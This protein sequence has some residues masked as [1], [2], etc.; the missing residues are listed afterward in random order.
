MVKTLDKRFLHVTRCQLIEETSFSPSRFYSWLKGVEE[1]K[2]RQP[3]LIPEEAV[4]GAVGVILDYPHFSGLK[5]QAYMIYHQLGVV[6]HHFYRSLKRIVGKIVF[7]EVFRRNLLPARTS[8]RHE[9]PENPGEIWAEDFTTVKVEGRTFYIGI[10]IDV[11]SNYYLGAAA[12]IRANAEF[13][14]APV[15]QALETN[16]DGPKRFML[17]DN[18]SQY[19]GDKHGQLLDKLDIVHKRIPACK[20]EYNGS[21]ECGVKEFKNVFYN[22]WANLKTTGISGDGA[23]LYRVKVAVADTVRRMNTE[24]P[25]PC[26]KG[27]TPNDVQ[28]SIDAEKIKRNQKYLE[29]ERAKKEIKPWTKNKW[30]LI[31]E[32]VSEKTLSDLELM[33]KFCFFLKRPL[34]K[35]ANLSLESV[36]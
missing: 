14:E 20:P 2:K 15:I 29:E 35:L 19:I 30:Q 34:R 11:F 36:G 22:I 6:S 17:S 31:Q 8:Y 24:I 9:R 26:L 3:K 32:V 16:G 4:R 23:L 5:G 21:C 33:T 28:K 10:L 13:V 12:S 25:R 27:V 1:R 18:G 7:Q